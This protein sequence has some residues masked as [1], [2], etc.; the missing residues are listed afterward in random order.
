MVSQRK[1]R[2]RQETLEASSF[3]VVAAIKEKAAAE[4]GEEGVDGDAKALLNTT[5]T[6]PFKFKQVK[7]ADFYITSTK[8]AAAK[9][10][11]HR[12]KVKAA[13]E[14]ARKRARTRRPAA[15]SSPR[16]AGWT[17]QSARMASSTKRE[18]SSLLSQGA[19]AGQE[20]QGANANK[21]YL[22]PQGSKVIEWYGASWRNIYLLS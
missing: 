10:D 5:A 16:R 13:R 17:S 7:L 6:V 22:P 8:A 12:E 4:E 2:S 18:K 21:S 9:E 3:T 14:K 15:K 20:V 19:R 11:A 1:K